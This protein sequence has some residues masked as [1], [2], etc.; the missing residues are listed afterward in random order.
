[1]LLMLSLMPLKSKLSLFYFQS[2]SDIVYI[3]GPSDTDV[4]M[5]IN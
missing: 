2:I 1:M 5:V 3:A 4:P